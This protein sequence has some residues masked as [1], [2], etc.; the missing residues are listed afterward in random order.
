LSPD[1]RD[2]KPDEIWLIKIDPA[3]KLSPPKKPADI[4]D[5]RNELSGDLSLNQELRAIESMNQWLGK[6]N[7]ASRGK[8]KHIT[9]LRMQLEEDAVKQFADGLLD[10]PSKAYRGTEFIRAL[11]A[12]GAEQAR[13]FLPIARQKARLRRL[14]EQGWNY[15]IGGT[16]GTQQGVSLSEIF[17]ANHEL[18]SFSDAMPA[19]GQAAPGPNGVHEFINKLKADCQGYLTGTQTATG[20]VSRFYVT[21]EDLIVEAEPAR[22]NE[23]LAA[24]RWTLRGARSDPNPGSVKIQGTWVSRLVGDKIVQ[25]WDWDTRDLRPVPRDIVQTHTSRRRFT[26]VPRRSWNIGCCAAG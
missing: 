11:M 21:I 25:S 18:V 5:R 2:E 26:R 14:F 8:Y 23:F 10:V 19:P 1:E 20:V 6:L 24:C 3:E 17:D 4:D 15:L 13:A 12:H 7:L 16:K 9:I 22:P